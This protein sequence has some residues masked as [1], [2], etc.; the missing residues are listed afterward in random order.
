MNNLLH[1]LEPWAETWSASIWRAS[2]QGAIAIAVAWIIARWCTFLSPR[3]IHWMWRLVCLK[4]LV[5]LVW[6]A[7]ISLA[8]LPPPAAVAPVTATFEAPPAPH[9]PIVDEAPLPEPRPV[10]QTAHPA[11]PT[12]LDSRV[13]LML[14][15][16]AGAL[17]L[18][19]VT[20]REWWSARRL[21]GPA[22]PASE[23]LHQLLVEESRRLGIPSMPRLRFSPNTNGPLLVGIWHPTIIL[24]Q[25]AEQAFQPAEI[26]LMLAHELAHLKR[27]DLAWNWLP[28][29]VGW[30]FFFHPLVWLLRRSWF[31]AQ[32]AACDEL[33]I[34]NHVARPA[35]FG[36]LLLKL[37]K[38]LGD[39][40]R[41]NLAAAGVL[42]AYENLHR[43]LAALSRVK[44]F[45]RP[46]TLALVAALI[47]IAGVATVPWR[48]V[49]QESNSDQVTKHSAKDSE[50][51]T[52][53][54][55]LSAWDR[56]RKDV[57][58]LEYEA[59]LG[60]AR[61]SDSVQKFLELIAASNP[62]NQAI[63]KADQ[64]D[65]QQN[66]I[67]LNRR[68]E[69]RTSGE[70]L[71][72]SDD[73]DSYQPDGK[74]T[75]HHIQKAAFDGIRRRSYSA[76]IGVGMGI[77]RAPG[78]PDDDVIVYINLQSFWL[79]FSPIAYFQQRGYKPAEMTITDTHVLF[80][81]ADCIKL[82]IPRE[83]S[84]KWKGFMIVDPS[85][86]YLP[87][88]WVEE[89]EGRIVSDLSI[90]YAPDSKIGWRVSG[91]NEKEAEQGKLGPSET[92]GKVTRFSV[93]ESLDDSLF[94]IEFP[95]GAD[96][97]QYT[98]KNQYHYYKV[99]D[100]GKLRP[101][102]DWDPPQRPQK[103]Q[104][105]SKN[106][107]NKEAAV[108]VGDANGDEN[109]KNA[110][111]A[112]RGERPDPQIIIA[113]HVLLWEG[114]EIV[115]WDEVLKRLQ[116][117]RKGG[118]VHPHFYT[119]NGLREKKV[120]GWQFW[121][122]RIMEVYP[123]L[124]QPAGVSFASVSPRG[125][126]RFD[127]IRNEDDLRPDATLAREG[128]VLDPDGKPAA[129]AQV[130]VLPENDILGVALKDTQ[131]RDPFDDKWTTADTDGRFT[132]YP[133]N[134][135]R[136]V[137]VL[138]PAGFILQKL[139]DQRG[140]RLQL[141]LDGWASV[142]FTSTG[143]TADQSADLT[144]VPTGVDGQ[145]PEFH[146]YELKA[147]GNAVDVKIPA[148]KVNLRR[149]LAMK[150]GT[151][152]S[153]PV[154]TFDLAPGEE[155]T[156][157]LSPPT[158][159]DR[160]QAGDE[161]K[162]FAEIRKRAAKPDDD[163]KSAAKQVEGDVGTATKTDG[164]KVA[165]TGAG[166]GQRIENH[167]ITVSGKA[168]DSNGKPIEGAT[169]FLVA[170]DISPEKTLGQTTTD[171]EGRYEFRNAQLAIVSPNNKEFQPQGS[172][173]VFGKSAGHAFAWQ[174]IRH[175]L[176][177]EPNRGFMLGATNSSTLGDKIEL[178]LTF[179][180]PKKI[181][182]RF[183]DKN[184]K[185]IV[186]V[187]V[188]FIGCNWL[189]GAGDQDHHMRAFLAMNQAIELMP[190]L[191]R[192]TSDAD[193][194]FEFASVPPEAVGRLQVKHPD[195]GELMLYTS[196]AEQPPATYDRGHP[197]TPLPINLTLH[198]A[199]TIPVLVQ[200]ADTGKPAD[201]IHVLAYQ[202]RA[203]G[204]SAAGKS[205]Q[206]GRITLKLPPGEYKLLAD[207]TREIDYVRSY[208]NLIVNEAPAEQPTTLKLKAGCVLTL[209]A[210]DADTGAG[211]PRVSFWYEPDDAKGSH[212]PVETNTSLVSYPETT[213]KGEVRAVVEP[214]KRRYGVGVVFKPLPDGYQAVENSDIS[215]GR[216]LELPAGKDVTVEF[217]LRK[218][219][220]GATAP[221]LDDTELEILKE[222]TKVIPQSR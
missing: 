82:A 166:A 211:I 29:I 11:P 30:L 129:G 125:S 95:K 13:I 127:A 22:K 115:T 178:D 173:E 132:I 35:E 208:Q 51:V 185:P 186:G 148:G 68:I 177:P 163:G 171:S 159:A 73:G 133:A 64:P 112:S 44:P 160:E 111:P 79:A 63:P 7:P 96:V 146:V 155:R 89:Y 117:L 204:Y 32:E 191:L 1:A 128:R 195:Y 209:K 219:A 212:Y 153:L 47:L 76:N 23:T 98:D 222:R 15:W 86:A 168:L 169:I 180:A 145:L 150:G 78:E 53:E 61:T 143:E 102:P 14:L 58:S 123:D 36:H 203:T 38:S 139:P 107:S 39:Q 2:W 16:V 100:D 114:K 152:I 196:T 184:A 31:E 141:K 149:T 205:D 24:P 220:A 188:E 43:R 49:A 83:G 214:G 110:A 192:T 165:D 71:A 91:W 202:K 140:E 90:K 175:V 190:E 122:D 55:I 25:D 176:L 157:E 57:K 92:T 106:G 21:R 216:E 126:N 119:T 20:L 147:R 124:F 156:L 130:V 121:H 26:R 65:G 198:T 197:V 80:G 109:K 42:G 75:S 210:T 94:T 18:A 81:G 131:L 167:P 108:A 93:N 181:A 154:D 28:T 72:Y 6:S 33:L 151:S 105:Q 217:K 135:E 88:Q 179:G 162:Q 27:H 9:F 137:A 74:P 134:D 45:S 182:G 69:F 183:V 62:Q 161:L 207:P 56:R 170:T 46:T 144:V 41:P 67:V 116:A 213:N 187:K 19:I 194:R 8:V 199:V 34:Q 218:Q 206:D 103:N 158:K 136:Y 172:F 10:A 193:G 142:T 189:A 54:K 77:V 215:S 85:R 99:D 48:L 60:I 104:G 120:G 50:H 5:A 101:N 66:V 37:A 17:A 113:E 70:K 59:D 138:H 174:P 87:L 97:L 201:A 118:P 164:E 40:A 12:P 221:K 200:L 4:L 52:V 3:V 84:E